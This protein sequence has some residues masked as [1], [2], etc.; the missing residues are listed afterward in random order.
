M[1]FE[2]IIDNLGW[3]LA[4]VY[5]FYMFLGLKCYFSVKN[6]H[7]DFQ[8]FR[9]N[10][11]KNNSVR[12]YF[13]PFSDLFEQLKNAVSSKYK[14]VVDNRIDQI[15]IEFER[16]IQLPISSIHS[17]T[18]SLILWGFV[19]TL[20]GSVKAFVAMSEMLE[21][22]TPISQAFKEIMHGKLDVALYS[23]LIAAFIAAMATTFVTTYLG[24]KI[25][26]DFEF[27]INDEIYDILLDEEEKI[28]GTDG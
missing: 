24:G 7:L 5:L 25:M 13:K 12:E 18:N 2:K 17:Y 28:E 8:D 6:I 15:W 10:N 4:V 3:P 27:N 19:G 23:S 11:R 20:Y 1:F 9:E 21:K 26:K 14:L 16:K 22:N